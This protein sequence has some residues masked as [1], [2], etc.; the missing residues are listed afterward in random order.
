MTE[1]RA[2]IR[3]AEIAYEIG[4]CGPDVIWA[5]GLSQSRAT[6]YALPLVDWSQVDARLLRYDA[7]G[8][9]MSE[10]TRDLDGYSWD[11]LARDQLALADYVGFGRYVCAGASMGCG[12]ALWAAVHDPDRIAK[13]LLVIPPTGWETRAEQAELWETIGQ[14]IETH[15]V[16][17]MIEAR[18]DIAPPDPLVDDPGHRERQ[19]RALRSWAPERLALVMRGA[20]K[21]DLPPR[22]A[23]A[24]ISAPA[25]I[26]AWTGDVVH[27]MAT[28]DELARLMPNATIQ[29][30]S[31]RT[32]LDSWTGL[33]AAFIT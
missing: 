24:S 27:P 9:G 13:L 3:G 16:E 23:V 28:A 30:A 20:G 25:L 32:E 31:T 22:A 26:L 17:A 6:E 7:R 1:A 11:Q 15:G 8:H 4:G 14:L 21:A 2:T 5:H 33:A 10:S 18:A 29:R 19:A 12:T